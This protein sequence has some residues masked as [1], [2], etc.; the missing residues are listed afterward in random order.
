MADEIAVPD[1]NSTDEAGTAVAEMKKL[2]QQVEVTDAGPCRKHVKVTIGRDAID[3]LIEEKFSD[4]MLKTPAQISGFRPGKAPRKIIERKFKT[5]VYSEAKSQ[6]LMASL[7]QLAEDSTLSPLS[8]PELDPYAVAIPDE[9]PMVYE[10]NIEV[11][12]EFDLP[13]YKNLKVKKPV[14]TFTDAEVAKE[15]ARILEPLGSLVPKDGPVALNDTVTVDA[16]IKEGDKVLNTV[17]EIQLK[18]E[19]RLALSDGVAQDFG[20]KMTGAKVGDTRTVDITLSQEVNAAA[21]RGAMVQAAFTV[22]DIK[23]TRP[24]EMNEGLYENFGVRNAEQFDEYVR[25]RLNR[26]MDYTQRNAARASVFDTLAKDAKFDLPQDLLLRQSRKTLQ[27]RV[28]EMRNS[29][30]TDDQIV[31]RQRVLEQDVV[32]TTAASLKE[33]FVLQK[34]A[35]LEKLEIEDEDIDAEIEAI[36]DRAGES[37]RK[38]KAKLEREDMIEALATE[39]LERKALD[40]VLATAEYEEYEF[41]PMQADEQ[42]DISVSDAQL[43]PQGGEREPDASAESAE[44]SEAPK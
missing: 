33:H 34:I 39:L 42:D 11:R 31:G 18:V 8:P 15:A 24:P 38:V 22:K 21:L 29:G 1:A 5:E 32:R 44:G 13:E 23:T 27:R 28:M 26:Y 7:E 20:Q 35:E 3:A 43:A 19:K 6:L 37:P 30:M 36:A 9:G 2:P 25:A 16:V 14:H 40:I 4:L 10:F 41:N 17:N 12:P